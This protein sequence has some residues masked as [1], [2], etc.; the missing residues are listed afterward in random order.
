MARRVSLRPPKR[1]EYTFEELYDEYWQQLHTQ[2]YSLEKDFQLAEDL[3]Q[4]SMLRVWQYWDRIQWDKLSG[5]IGTIANNV[6]FGYMRKYLNR[7]DTQSYD[8]TDGIF[9][10]E[11]H[12]NGITDPMRQMLQNE[13]SD[14]VE[15][16]LKRLTDE[17]MSLFSDMYLRNFDIK[18]LTIKYK[19]SK[20]NV[21]VRLHRVRVKMLS[22]LQNRGIDY[23]FEG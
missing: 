4:E 17:E 2:F 11:C 1:Q 21:Y 14:H 9:E 22:Y 8:E 15:K 18:D 5:A 7:V 19:M 6:R 3:A 10:F 23:C 13:A 16:A 12:D 20:T